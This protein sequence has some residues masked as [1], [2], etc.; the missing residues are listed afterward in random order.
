MIIRSIYNSWKCEN[1]IKLSLGEEICPQCK[2]RGIGKIIGQWQ[3]QCPKC[4]GEG[5][6][7]WISKARGNDNENFNGSL[8][9]LFSKGML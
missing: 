4:K 2:G 6:V 5:K 3:V 9:F 8:Q 1:E 7:D